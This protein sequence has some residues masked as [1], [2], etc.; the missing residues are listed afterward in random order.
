MAEARRHPI[1]QQAIDPAVAALLGNQAKR[2]AEM[3]LPTKERVRKA[4]QR[5]KDKERL[6][7]RVN[8]EIPTV[9]KS[10]INE[11]A[12]AEE[13]PAS[14]VASLLILLGLQDLAANRVRIW[15]FKIPS[16]S[17]RY[18]FVLSLPLGDEP[19]ELN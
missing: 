8:W 16:T 6:E 1:S 3:Q 15:D 2:Q 7:R 13:V 14:Q 19:K 9:L 10:Q 11:L 17:P 4:K 5:Q 12:D 18:N